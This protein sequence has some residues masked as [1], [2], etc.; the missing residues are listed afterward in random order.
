MFYLA[1]C[2]RRKAIVIA[3]AVLLVC[4]G[5]S[6][7]V[8]AAQSGSSEASK[9][10]TMN[11]AFGTRNTRKCEKVTH[12]PSATE[13]A[14]LSQCY[15][16]RETHDF[17]LLW[18]NLHVQIGGARAYAYNVDSHSSDIDTTAKV[19]PI[20]ATGNHYIC[21]KGDKTCTVEHAT[22]SPGTCFKTTFGDWSCSFSFSFNTD[23]TKT[24]QPL[25]TT[26]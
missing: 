14:A 25:P 6:E 4:T 17:I 5:T 20:R 3:Y 1:R 11:Q 15:L 23:P 19:Y 16:E 18:Q 10:P 12:V 2:M 8:L 7:A 22:D 9:P 24:Q 13:A 21:G 26:Y